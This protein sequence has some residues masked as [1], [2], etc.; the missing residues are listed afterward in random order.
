MIVTSVI[1]FIIFV[2]DLSCKGGAIVS[3]NHLSLSKKDQLD[4]YHLSSPMEDLPS[5]YLID[6]MNGEIYFAAIINHCTLML[7]YWPSWHYLPKST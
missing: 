6:H 4:D 2:Y 5:S 7:I 3:D 1:D